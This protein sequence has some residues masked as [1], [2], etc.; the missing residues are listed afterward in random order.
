MKKLLLAIGVIAL[1]GCGEQGGQTPNPQNTTQTKQDQQPQN[2]QN[3]PKA[4]N[5]QAGDK[6]KATQ[7]ANVSCHNELIIQSFKNQQSNIQVGGC[8]TVV[9]TLADDNE[10]SRHQKFIVRLDGYSDTVLIAHNIDLAP[11]VKGLKKGDNLSFYGEYE[12]TDKGG[13]V[14][15]THHDPAGRHQGGW[16]L[17]NGQKYE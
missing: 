8:G 4:S 14:H 1:F 12:Y 6:D 13:V 15:W 3:K 9:A 11:Y 10:G 5:E 16:I 17:F 2:T 7:Q